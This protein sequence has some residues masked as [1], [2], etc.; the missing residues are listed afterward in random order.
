MKFKIFSIFD[1]K[2]ENYNTPMFLAAKGQATRAF[3]DETNRP[4]SEISKHP[5]DYTL[6][7]L[8][9]YDSDTGKIESLNTPESLGLALEY[10]RSE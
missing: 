8:G 5:E 10:K 9:E 4:E 3:D 6:F 2:A 7:C 1:S